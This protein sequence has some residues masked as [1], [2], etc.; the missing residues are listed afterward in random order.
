MPFKTPGITSEY[1]RKLLQMRPAEPWE[2]RILR[3]ADEHMIAV[4]LPETAAFLRQT[5]LL[6][7]P[8]RILE[9]GTAIGYSGMLMLKAAPQSQLYSV[10][11]D[12]ERISTAKRFFADEKLLSRVVFYCGDA[13]V[14]VPNLSGAFDFILL[15]GPKA[16]Y[17]EYLPFLSR[18]LQ[19]NGILFCDNVL[20]DGMVS[21]EK[22]I[23]NH[24]GGLVGKLDLFLHKLMADNTLLSS[25]L[26]VGDGVSLSIKRGAK[27]DSE[28]KAA[29]N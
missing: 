7:R 28:E 24:K 20:Y 17:V 8:Q 18:L 6:Q 14:V 22:E 27:H 5:V 15:D 11:L 21:G 25:I 19:P 12:E 9:I 2:E 13:S 4:L 16:Q 10:E 1:I 23:K 26:P 3:F 29:C